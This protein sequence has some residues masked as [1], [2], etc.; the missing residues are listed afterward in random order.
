MLVLCRS[1]GGNL[2]AQAM[3]G[4]TPFPFFL[5]KKIILSLLLFSIA[6]STIADTTYTNL[7]IWT[8][9][10]SKI[11]YAVKDTPKITFTETDAVVITKNLRAIYNVDDLIRFTYEKSD[12]TN[13]TKLCDNNYSFEIRNNEI[14]FHALRSKDV[15]IMRSLDGMLISKIIVSK[16][17]THTFP[18]S[19]L[20][21][22]IYIIQ[23]NNL[24]YK[25]FKR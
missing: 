24:S 7:V 5:M 15:F 20:K 12:A 2:K 6:I 22:G 23:L 1:L 8:K 19:N 9:D 25:I 21:A 13:I 11:L 14:T 17:G 4:C 3:D 10:G 18:M 16:N